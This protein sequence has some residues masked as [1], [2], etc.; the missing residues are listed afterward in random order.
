MS[1]LA[2]YFRRDKE[3]QLRRME[4]RK[5]LGIDLESDRIFYAHQN[6]PGFV[7]GIVRFFNEADASYRALQ[8][9]KERQ[10]RC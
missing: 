10:H 2:S 6:D 8:A 4:I 3:A 5:K 1:S 7:E 9:E